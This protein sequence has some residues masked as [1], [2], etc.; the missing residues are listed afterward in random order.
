MRQRLLAIHVLARG[1]GVDDHLPMLVIGNRDDDRIDILAVENLLVIAG[2]GDGLADRLLGGDVAAIPQI[3][4][5][6][7]LNARDQ[8]ARFQ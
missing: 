8:R 2:R 4:N 6:D 1:A 7:A 5:P 3:A